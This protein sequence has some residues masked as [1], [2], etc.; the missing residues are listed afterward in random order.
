[1]FAVPL[2]P[3]K[4]KFSPEQIKNEVERIRQQIPVPFLSLSIT[5]RAQAIKTHRTFISPEVNAILWG[6]YLYSE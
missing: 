3:K 2:P 1:M 5:E 6:V 4:A